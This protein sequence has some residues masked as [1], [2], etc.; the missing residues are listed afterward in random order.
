MVRDNIH[1]TSI[2]RT[3]LIINLKDKPTIFFKCAQAHAS[4]LH[5]HT[6]ITI[7]PTA[8]KSTPKPIPRRKHDSEI[9]PMPPSSNHP[10]KGLT[11]K[12]HPTQLQSM[13]KKI[14][15][16]LD[17]S[18]SSLRALDYAAHISKKYNAEL[19][20][21]SAAERLPLPAFE[22][23]RASIYRPQYQEDLHKSLEKIQKEQIAKLA[24]THPGLNVTGDVI[25]GR[26][27]TVIKEAAQ[28]ADLIVIGH[29]GHGGI[30]SWILGSVAKQVVDDSTVP[31]LVVKNKDYGPA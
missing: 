28:G 8:T 12:Y 31:V 23:S 11:C 24:K 4:G 21:V 20:I 27:A 2:S 9:K 3:D 15:I 1:H 26:P 13:F 19:H 14:L 16:A 5:L 10:K 25:D 7:K 29:R 17:G 22:S 18:D 6:D 30:L